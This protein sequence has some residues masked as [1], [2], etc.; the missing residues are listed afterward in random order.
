MTDC[1]A[2]RTGRG[3]I[4]GLGLLV[5]WSLFDL[6]NVGS[7]RYYELISLIVFVS[8]AC[9]LAAVLVARPEI[10]LPDAP[11]A[12]VPVAILLVG[13]VVVFQPTYLVSHDA[14]VMRLTVLACSVT[15]CL[16]WLLNWPGAAVT[17]C[18]VS[19]VVLAVTAWIPI[20]GVPIPG[21]DVWFSLQQGIDG[22]GRGDN[23]YLM[24]WT[25]VPPGQVTDAFTYLPMSAVLLAPAR[26]IVG[27]VRWGLAMC[28]L[29]SSVLL[30]AAA[31]PSPSGGGSTRLWFAP[32]CLLPLTAGHPLQVE[33]S[34]TEPLLLALLVGTVL[35]TLRGRQWLAVGLLALAL[36][37]KQHVWLLLPLFVAWRPFGL[38]RA[39]FAAVAAASLCLPWLIADPRAMFRDTVTFLIDYPA[40]ERS[41]TAYALLDRAGVGLPV[42]VAG[43][44]V[45][46]TVIW[47]SRRMMR[48]D[49]GPFE[50]CLATALVLLVANLVNKQAY[51]NQWWLVGSLVL[52]ALAF[53]ERRPPARSLSMAAYSP[54][55]RP[56]PSA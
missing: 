54:T 11:L 27:D 26:W 24:T 2:T 38:R 56:E 23:M 10:A 42:V 17:S 7:H 14:V 16:L 9:L 21:N 45:L 3:V 18:A 52:S 19:T 8:M 48:H 1:G 39:T 47:C 49:A 40:S 6:A 5:A 46:A 22:L 12:A 34:W 20:H 15:L 55:G 41:S 31:R 32:A 35:S 36:A 50:L 51:Y 25:G 44:T 33:M 29:V 53:A 43:A 30:L 13:S 4:S 28:V 37:S